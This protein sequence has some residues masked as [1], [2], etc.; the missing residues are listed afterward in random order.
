MKGGNNMFYVDK[1]KMDLYIK[2]NTRFYIYCETFLD[3]RCATKMLEQRNICWQNRQTFEEYT[4]SKF[5]T[6]L[7]YNVNCRITH[8]SSA[9]EHYHVFGDNIFD[10]GL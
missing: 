8:D 7:F 1:E 10:I 6:Y 2:L 5:P 9:R 4:P 3:Y